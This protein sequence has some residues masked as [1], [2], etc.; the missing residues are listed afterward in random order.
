MV[1]NEGDE[2]KRASEDIDDA[3]KGRGVPLD[4]DGAI[5]L[6]VPEAGTRDIEPTVCLL[7]DDAVGDELKVLVDSSNILEDLSGVLCTSSQIWL[8]QI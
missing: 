7:H 3:D 5:D 2:S 8:V 1:K 4:S 6:V